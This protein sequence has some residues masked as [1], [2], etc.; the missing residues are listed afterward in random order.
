MEDQ[1][2]LQLF[3]E[4]LAKTKA[5]RIRWEPTASETQYASILPSGH[6]L[7]V[8]MS[9]RE[10]SYGDPLSDAFVLV[11]RR[12]DI[13]QELLRV[14]SDVDGVGEEGLSELYEFARRRALQVDATVDQVLGDLAKL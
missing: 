11:L 7:L 1:K 9:H 4:V 13:E 12:R 6:A 5:G 3:Q 14:T 10:N 2:A 8:S